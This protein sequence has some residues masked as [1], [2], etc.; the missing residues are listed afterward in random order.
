[1]AFD[2][3]DPAAEAHILVRAAFE[4]STRGAYLGC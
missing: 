1:V 4:I 3:I 2:D